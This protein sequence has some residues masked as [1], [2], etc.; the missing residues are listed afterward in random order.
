MVEAENIVKLD[1]GAVVVHILTQ[2]TGQ[3]IQK[4]Q[5]V[6]FSY[7]ISC[8]ENADRVV[9]QGEKTVV[10]GAS[11]WIMGLEMAL[12]HLNCDSTAKIAI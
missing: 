11:Q 5:K 4:G 1:K 3:K 10:C 7:E 12:E 2:G 9:D 6:T 8:M